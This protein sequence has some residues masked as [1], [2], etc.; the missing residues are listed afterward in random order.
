[1]NDLLLERIA[2]ALERIADSLDAE[3]V[4]AERRKSDAERQAK[5]RALS[6][7][8]ASTER[9]EEAKEGCTIPRI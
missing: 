5:H 1:M 7:D 6:R 9:T 8:I 3:R 4:L 2:A